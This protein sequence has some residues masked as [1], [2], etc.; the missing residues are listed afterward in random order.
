MGWR[1]AR[2][3]LDTVILAKVIC[4][5]RNYY[6]Q[7][8][9]QTVELV[10]SVFNPK[11]WQVWSPEGVKLAWELVEGY[12]PSLGL[13]DE[14]A[15]AKQRAALIENEVMDLI[16]WTKSGG[17]VSGEDLR[18]VFAEWNPDLNVTPREFGLAVK[19]VTGLST[20][21]SNGTRYWVGFHLPTSEE[22]KDQ[23]PKA[24]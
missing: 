4:N 22:E 20:R 24:A 7:S 8:A 2:F 6:L 18:A 13:S 21:T 16:A 1:A 10:R 14:K 15:V 9:E 5:L 12:T 3:D 17:R 23:Y 19:A 11:S